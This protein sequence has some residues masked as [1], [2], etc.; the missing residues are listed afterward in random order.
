METTIPEISSVAWTSLFT[1]T[2]PGTHGI[3]GFIDLVPGSYKMTFPNLTS[4][5]AP[6]LWDD[7]GARGRRSIVIN[8]PSTYPAKPIAGVLISGFVAIHLEKSVTPLSLLPMLRDLGYR[9][10]VDTNRARTDK[11]ALVR[12][13]KETFA[14]RVAVIERLMATEPWDF[15]CGVITGTDRLH[16]FLWDAYGDPAH[17]HHAFFLDYYAGIDRLIGSLVDRLDA[18]T[19]F[20]MFSDHGFTGIVQEVHLNTW[21]RREGFLTL[22]KEKPEGFQDLAPGTRAFALDP[23]RIHI[24]T[25]G[26]WPGGVVDP[27]AERAALI[28]EIAEKALALTDE[29]GARVVD[30]VCRGEEIY[31]GP[32][33]HLGPDLVLVPRYGY[34][35]KGALGRETLFGRTPLVGMHTQDDAMFYSSRRV[36]LDRTVNIVDV[37]R[38][39]L[40]AI[41]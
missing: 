36:D 16:H 18:R 31:S 34:D 9:I 21:L 24:H 2:N 7:L 26:R 27:G 33:A 12:D 1:G 39:I 6:A 13:L 19:T 37:K 23:S 20:L 8:M 3:Y 10:D 22:T 29:T 11:D 14:A 35:L 40:D 5:K 30:R 28:A 15:F 25:R 17:A 41:G 38:L 4:V 32:C